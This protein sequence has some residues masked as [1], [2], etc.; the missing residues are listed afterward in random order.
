MEFTL[1]TVLEFLKPFLD[2]HE[3]DPNNVFA[4]QFE[5]GGAEVFQYQRTPKGRI[6]TSG[7]EPMMDSKFYRYLA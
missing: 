1:A 4:I 5:P 2:A 7:G 6:K 3:L